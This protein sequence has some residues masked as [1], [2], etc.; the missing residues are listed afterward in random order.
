VLPNGLTLLLRESH[1]APVANIQLWVGVGSADERDGEQGLAHFHEHMLFKGTERRGVGE[2]AG[3]VEGAG[4]RI[5]AYTSFDV[6]V[7][8]ATLPSDSIDT[9][10]DVLCDALRFS[11]FDADEVQ[12]E[13]EVV[14]EEIRRSNDSPGHVLGDALFDAS[15]RVHPYGLPILG[16]PENVASFDR[17]RVR[18]FF[19]RWYRPDNIVVVAAGDFDSAQ[20]RALAEKAF[21]GAEPGSAGRGRPVEPIREAA[22]SLLLRGPFERARLELAWPGVAF[23]HQDAVYLDLLAFVLG[24]CDSSRLVRRVKE[25]GALAERVDASSYTPLDPGLFSVSGETEPERLLAAVE[26]IATEVE[27]L[28]FEPVSEDELDRARTIFLSGEHFERESVSGLAHK[29][30]SF[31]VFGGDWRSE[32]SYFE[33]IRRATA[34]DLLRVAQEYLPAERVTAAA[35]IQEDQETGLDEAALAAAVSSGA[36]RARRAM[37][38]PKALGDPAGGQASQS[39]ELPGGGRLH[40]APRREIPVVAAR[41]AFLGGQLAENAGTAGI[42]SFLTSLWLRGTKGRSAADLAR[43]I[44]GI[45]ADLDGF[46]GRNSLGLALE[47]ASEELDRG[48]DLFAEVLLEPAFDE[49]EIERERR[50]TLAAIDRRSDQLAQQAFQLF[51]ETLFREHPYRLPIVGERESVEGFSADAMRA[52]QERLISADNLVIAIAGDVD[53]DS[54]AEAISRRL[55]ELPT[56]RGPFA[57]PRDE[58]APKEARSVTREK[59]RAQTHLVAGFRGL[60]V[61]DPDRHALEVLAQVLAGQS[62]RLFLELRDRQSL[63]YSVSAV[64]VEG[65]APGLFAIYIATAPDKVEAAKRGM[66]EELERLLTTPP[67]GDELERARR[68]LIGNFAIDQQ[69]AAARAAHM[70]LDSLYGLGPDAS[71]QYPSEVRQIGVDDVQRVARRVIDL[72]AMVTSQVG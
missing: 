13:T 59:E 56:G 10:V 9:G 22:Q 53:P 67:S 20:V 69:R 14:L 4:G 12:R 33:A 42:S 8:H 41:A 50:D 68:Y 18:S 36:E 38:K 19:E 11:R 26:A 24:E 23:R 62:G 30:G 40:V 60:S 64:N 3:E 70:A 65:V 45:A 16:P 25:R 44:E 57:M 6:T 61:D 52:H 29:L 27:R 39:Y 63:A 46:S 37:R 21:D 72:D 55:S 43:S 58:E 7:Y 35:L 34:D 32:E 5:N 54:V 15:Y 1:H 28:R 17:E 49:N 2:V 31:H 47:V 51:G 66:Q 48:L 71:L